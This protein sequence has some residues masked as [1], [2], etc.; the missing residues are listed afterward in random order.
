M[1]RIIHSHFHRRRSGVT[2]HVE[3][4]VGALQGFAPTHIVQFGGSVSSSRHILS[5][6]E[7]IQH[8]R[9]EEP[10]VWHAHRNNEL[11]FA[12]ALKKRFR[13]I[14]LVHTRHTCS[15]PSAL[16]RYLSNRVDARIAI[17][18]ES[19]V[20]S[21]YPTTIVHHGVDDRRFVSK[22]D[23]GRVI[24]EIADEKAICIATVG[25]IRPDKGQEIL[26]DAIESMLRDDARLHVFF[27]GAC[28]IEHRGWLKNL[29]ARVPQQIHHIDEERNIAAW[30]QSIDI[31]V[32]PSLREGQGLVLFEA[33]ASGCCVIAS[34]IADLGDYIKQ[35]T[36]GWLFTP[37]DHLALR[38]SLRQ[39]ITSSRRRRMMGEAAASLI[40]IRLTM[41]HEA[42]K[43][44]DV[45]RKVLI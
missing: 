16:T 23:K 42:E 33:M 19:L 32:M 40:R 22:R 5:F 3:S 13:K 17:T 10:V 35:G 8:L 36:N 24:K 7:L 31:M 26:L 44:C 30:Y 12:M 18:R 6:N 28:A 14:L 21:K 4:I 15:K 43:L 41:R 11:L 1:V 45:Y 34:D 20:W 38:H 39:A 25:R 27:I 37:G 9:T 2:S 29:C